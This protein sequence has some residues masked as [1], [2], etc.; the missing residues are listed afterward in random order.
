M[1]KP[2]ILLLSFALAL[3]VASE[4]TAPKERNYKEQARIII[5]VIAGTTTVGIYSMLI[6]KVL[7]TL[8]HTNESG[9]LGLSSPEE[10]PSTIP[11]VRVFKVFNPSD[12]IVQ[13]LLV[14]LEHF[15]TWMTESK[16]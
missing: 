4:N 5:I 2:V 11:N 1:K 9:V 13:G 10:H 8:T 16:P 7:G 14:H 15:D 6:P 12:E 3:N